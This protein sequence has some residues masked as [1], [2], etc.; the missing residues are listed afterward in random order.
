MEEFDINPDR[1]QNAQRRTHF[2]ARAEHHYISFY[3]GYIL[4][5]LL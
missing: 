5:K 2:S 3:F 1:Y 4:Y